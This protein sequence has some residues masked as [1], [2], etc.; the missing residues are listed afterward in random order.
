MPDTP[1]TTEQEHFWAGAFG[2]AYAQRNQGEALIVSNMALFSRVL[3]SAPGVRSIIELGC[4]VGLNLQALHRINPQFDLCG[5]EINAAAAAQ[6][7]A[8]QIAQVIQGSV[9]DDLPASAA[10]DLSFTKGV[11]IH[12]DPGALEKVYRNLYALSRRYILACEY[13]NPTPVAV[14]YRGNANRLFKRDFA[15]ELM[16]R[17]NLRLID[18]GF[19]YRRDNYFPQDDLT[20]FL[21]EK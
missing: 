14:E 16:D 5:Y 19:A 10:H 8:L 13:Y 20:W 15:G 7:G 4:N 1:Y 3:K 18:Y 11:L 2:D 12:I 6:A 9:L 17:F 21:L